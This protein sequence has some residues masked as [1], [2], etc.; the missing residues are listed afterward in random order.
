MDSNQLKGRQAMPKVAER[1]V[2]PSLLVHPDEE[3]LPAALDHGDLRGVA[4]DVLGEGVDAEDLGHLH[5]LGGHRD[6]PGA[7]VA[8][9]LVLGVDALRQ[10]EHRVL[11]LLRPHP[12]RTLKNTKVCSS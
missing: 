1:P 5:E 2:R 11:V 8:V 9:V 4:Q 6:G 7:R 3:Y 12:A 10:E